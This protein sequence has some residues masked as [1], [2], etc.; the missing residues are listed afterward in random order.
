MNEILDVKGFQV[1]PFIG[2]SCDHAYLGLVNTGD[3]SDGSRVISRVGIG[4]KFW[5]SVN[6][7]DGSG[8]VSLAFSVSLVS[9]VNIQD[10][11][12]R[13]WQEI[14]AFA[15][16]F[17]SHTTK[18]TSAMEPRKERVVGTW[19]IFEKEKSRQIWEPCERTLCV[20]QRALLAVVFEVPAV[21]VIKNG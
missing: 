5:S 20:R 3:R 2:M 4:R 10:G 14:A 12:L 15:I 16:A 1:V 17:Y 21:P 18:K 8:I 9:F 11:G 6:R 13:R 7:H 19:S